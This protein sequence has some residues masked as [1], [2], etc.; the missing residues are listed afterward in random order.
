MGSLGKISFKPNL[1]KLKSSFLSKELIYDYLNNQVS[2]QKKEQIEEALK[3]NYSV[4]L[5]IKRIQ[6]AKQF[7]YSIRHFEVPGKISERIEVLQEEPVISPSKFN[8]QQLPEGI[9]QAVF[10][11]GVVSV[12]LCVLLL[13]PWH[14]IRDLRVDSVSQEIVSLDRSKSR[15]S[16]DLAEAEKNEK[17][18][19]Q[20][21]TGTEATDT[22]TAVPTSIAKV[23]ETSSPPSVKP[24]V[25]PSKIPVVTQ[26]PETQKPVAKAQ[27]EKDA[28]PKSS[29]ALAQSNTTPGPAPSIKDVEAGVNE[30]ATAGYLYRGQMKLTNL[31]V[32][33]KRL[34]EKIMELGGRKA[35]EVDLGWKRGPTTLYYHFTIPEARYEEL[36]TFLSLYGQPKINKEK[37]PRV[38]PEGIIRLILTI[39]EE[40]Q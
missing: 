37:H 24:V 31:E 40:K 33:G 13:I 5:E 3:D 21:E 25:E 38:M 7:L 16:M 18:L 27:P 15:S 22:V 19:F 32:S 2:D 11:L 1:K 30:S 39:D 35:G 14:K 10:A 8:V 29:A 28:N 4:R 26:A 20:D 34:T 6:S 36:K 9:R 12:L 17:P 23:T